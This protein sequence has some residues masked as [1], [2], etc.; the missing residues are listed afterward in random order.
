MSCQ[1]WIPPPPLI[2]YRQLFWVHEHS[3]EQTVGALVT[4]CRDRA[5]WPR[6]GGSSGPI[7]AITQTKRFLSLWLK[8]P[9]PLSFPSLW[10]SWNKNLHVLYLFSWLLSTPLPTVNRLLLLCSH[11]ST[12]IILAKN[13]NDLPLAKSNGF[14]TSFCMTFQ[15]SSVIT[16]IMERAIMDDL[17]WMHLLLSTY[18][19]HCP[20]L[21]ACVASQPFFGVGTL[22]FLF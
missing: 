17:C 20:K 5:P 10:R 12:G 7:N 11:T 16:L 14:Q 9:L 2:T 6:R 22:I 15:V 13:I 4:L 1:V 21:I 19:A 3:P 18:I 8:F